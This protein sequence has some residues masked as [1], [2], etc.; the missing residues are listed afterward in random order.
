MEYCEIC[1][2]KHQN[3]ADKQKHLHIDTFKC[4]ICRQHFEDLDQLAR[5]YDL[6][7]PKHDVINHEK[8]EYS[9]QKDF[10]YFCK[11]CG[12]K[13]YFISDLLSH[14]D[15]FHYDLVHEKSDP[16][17]E[18]PSLTLKKIFE[19]P[20][21]IPGLGDYDDEVIIVVESPSKAHQISDIDQENV[22][23]KTI[24]SIDPVDTFDVDS[25]ADT[26][27]VDLDD[28]SSEPLQNDPSEIFLDVHE[29]LK[30]QNV[31][32]GTDDTITLSS[33]EED[34]WDEAANQLANVISDEYLLDAFDEP[35][36]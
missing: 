30:E 18:D 17:N 5:H 14:K 28:N 4:L 9:I 32:M 23:N 26:V 31:N 25:N 2:E 8:T 19:K 21:K 11:F 34:K 22:T 6:C 20:E 29:Y 13:Y 15:V 33:S 12:N 7:H 1:G 35:P 10:K 36:E 27:V 3:L 16:K 24:I